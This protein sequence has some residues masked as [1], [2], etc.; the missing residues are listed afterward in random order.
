[1]VTDRVDV[2]PLIQRSGVDPSVAH[3]DVDGV[4]EQFHQV[5]VGLVLEQ[6]RGLLDVAAGQ[7]VPRRH[8][9]LELHQ[10]RRCLVDGLIRAQDGDVIAALRNLYTKHLSG[11]REVLAQL[12]DHLAQRVRV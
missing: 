6:P 8:D 4:S 12:A 5:G 3:T 10:Q 1:M 11:H 9:G 2:H 7:V